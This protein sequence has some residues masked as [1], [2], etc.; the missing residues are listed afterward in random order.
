MV[1]LCQFNP[2]TTKKRLNKKNRCYLLFHQKV[3]KIKREEKTREEFLLKL[4]KSVSNLKMTRIFWNCRSMNLLNIFN[5]KIIRIGCISRLKTRFLNRWNSIRN[6][7]QAKEFSQMFR[8]SKKNSS[9]SSTQ[10]Q[11][12]MALNITFSNTSAANPMV[13]ATFFAKVAKIT[14]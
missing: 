2:L 8:N 9:E 5:H 13:S 6:S 14:F 7:K 4:V 11:N 3:L 1:I 10:F 12:P